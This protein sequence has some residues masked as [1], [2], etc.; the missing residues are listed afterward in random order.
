MQEFKIFRALGLSFKSWFRNFIPFTLIAAVLYSPVILWLA[1]IDLSATR[2]VE[3]LLND[4]FV[5][6]IYA[7]VGLSALLAPM[8]TYRVIQELNGT[9][10]S[11]MA[12]VKFGMRGILPAI[13]LA[14]LTNVA[15]LVPM[16]GIISAIITCIWF[17]A[18]PA[19]V[20]EQLGPVT[21]FTRSSE[22]TR[23]RRWG[24]FGLTFLIGLALVALLMAWVIPMFEKS[25]ADLMSTM[26]QSAIMFVVTMGIFQMFTGI[27]QAVSY[28]LL[29]LDKE[30]VTHEELAKV[31]E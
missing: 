26:R 15:Q 13:L 22:L 14:V 24:I 16:G 30:G 9:K 2:S 18:A 6:P 12:S 29:R 20:A 23:G 7:L 3:D 31:F 1:T 25:E 21:A 11:M 4:V 17:V 27:V 19:A 5:R 8:L 10:V 28:A